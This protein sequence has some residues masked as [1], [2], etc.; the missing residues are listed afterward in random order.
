M[1]KSNFILTGGYPLKAERLQEMQTAYQTLNAFG[2]LAG[3]LTIISGCETIGSTVKNGFVYI[4][5][6]L[7]EFR[8]AAKNVDSKVIIVEEA[9]SKPFKNGAIKQVYTI[10]YATFGNSEVSSWLWTEFIRPLETK[11]L[12]ARMEL[13][14]KKLAIFQP[15]G[16]VFPWFKPIE[17]IPTGFQQVTNI[18]GRMI[19]GYDP[20]QAEFNE[21]GKTAGFKSKTLSIS[22]IP[23]HDHGLKVTRLNT[24]GSGGSEGVIRGNVETERTGSSGG[25]QSFSILNPYIIAEYI[26]FIG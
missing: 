26:E 25:G 17:D 18:K 16:V 5:N 22:E 13:I 11:S 21:I 3:N 9:V 14:E 20:S 1:N 8:E 2:S 15:G 12:N 7:L 24:G 4:D 19:I 6:E 10:R 23:A